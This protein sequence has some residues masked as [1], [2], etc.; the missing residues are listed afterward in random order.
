[1]HIL[2]DRPVIVYLRSL[3]VLHDFYVPQFRAKMDLVPGMVTYFWFIPVR[4]GEFEI[5]CAELC[6]VGHS[7]MR[8][9]VVVD[10]AVAYQVWLAEQV[11]FGGHDGRTRGK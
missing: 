9:L 11:T 8:G 5:L 2:L 4:T 3:D 1:M 6:G 7:Q 10:D